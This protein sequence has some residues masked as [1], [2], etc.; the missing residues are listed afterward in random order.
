MLNSIL[1]LYQFLEFRQT[2]W[3]SHRAFTSWFTSCV[4][5]VLVSFPPSPVVEENEAMSLIPQD[6][7]VLIN[8]VGGQ[9]KAES[10]FRKVVQPLFDQAN[11]KYEIIVTGIDSYL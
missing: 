6:F 5:C 3:F 10:E 7:L 4:V 2:L 11:I 8:P 9:G 1:L